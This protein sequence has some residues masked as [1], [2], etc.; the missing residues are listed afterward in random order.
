M[1]NICCADTST[2]DYKTNGR[3][4]NSQDEA[5]QLQGGNPDSVELQHISEREHGW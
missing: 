3:V 1:G 4:K 2:D 5:D